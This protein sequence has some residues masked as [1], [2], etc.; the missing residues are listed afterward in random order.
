MYVHPYVLIWAGIALLV[1]IIFFWNKIQ[2]KKYIIKLRCDEI[3][4][5]KN[6]KDRLA[7]EI[8]DLC[9]E[10]AQA[11][12]GLSVSKKRTEACNTQIFELKKSNRL[13]QNE[14]NDYRSVSEDNV[15]NH[16]GYAK[17]MCDLIAQYDRTMKSNLSQRA[18]KAAEIVD[19]IKDENKQLMYERSSLFAQLAV[20]EDL[21]PWLKELKDIPIELLRSDSVVID[22][23]A[24]DWIGVWENYK[25][26]NEENLQ[27]QAELY[28][29][30]NLLQKANNRNTQNNHTI[31]REIIT[32]ESKR[33]EDLKKEVTETQNHIEE[34]LHEYKGI[35]TKFNSAN[36]ATR[37]VLGI[38]IPQFFNDESGMKKFYKANSD[39]MKIVS[40]VN[41]SCEILSENNKY[42][43]TGTSCTCEA[44]KYGHG[45]PCKHMLHLALQFG[46]AFDRS[47]A[48][49]AYSI[50]QESTEE[51][52]KDKEEIGQS[53]KNINAQKE[54]IK[55]KS[56][57]LKNAEIVLKDK[58]QDHPGY[59]SFIQ[60]LSE[61]LDNYRIKKL[62]VKAAKSADIVREIK[63]EK[64][65]L[66]KERSMLFA[67][68]AVYEDLFPWLE[69]F[70]EVP[71]EAAKAYVTY[72]DSED[73]EY[74][75][76]WLSP[77]E[78]SKLP[79]KERLQLA[80]DRW[81]KR[82]KTD[83]EA[84]ID[85]ERY[86]G[87]IYEQEGYNVTYSGALN[88]LED[89]GRD[90]VALKGNTTIVI[91]CKR[92]KEERQIHEK[93]IFQLFGTS[94]L[95]GLQHPKEKIIPLFVTTGTLSETAQKCAEKLDIQV[96]HKKLGDYPMIKCNVNRTTGEKIYHLPFDQQYDKIIIEPEKGEQYVFTVNE[97]E[98]L[99]YRHAFKH[100]S[101]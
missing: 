66:I 17:I 98:S 74:Y 40:P 86:I 55:N 44:F 92:W 62:S 36:H 16:P 83:W 95:Y 58:S 97:A 19:Q 53:W 71:L 41:F 54:I 7:E 84:G 48:L 52:L 68:L 6:E 59:A 43:T 15:Q 18:Y 33:I 73:G 26:T 24:P 72:S 96:R 77:E 14:V 87:Y 82:K 27:L 11:Q 28:K 45:K 50:L 20:Y 49:K 85:Y 65:Q 56:E 90:L 63:A 61:S 3:Y 39:E 9:E 13:L 67:Q 34:L 64:R 79:Q 51:V 46:F 93:H 4:K 23:D 76:N 30:K 75:K 38:D 42:I 100:F 94:I 89:M 25:K 70:K 57:A 78:Y 47:D 60:D 32:A 37:F 91:Q 2:D 8:K 22:K 31:P 88:G 35:T 81:Q 1:A 29:L 99:G 10:V 12:H 101:N 80:L 69:E 21:F 5:L